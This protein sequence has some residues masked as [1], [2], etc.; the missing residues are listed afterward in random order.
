MEA[1]SRQL[2]WRFWRLWTLTAGGAGAAGGLIAYLFWAL[3]PTPF[4]FLLM[5]PPLPGDFGFPGCFYFECMLLLALETFAVTGAILTLAFTVAG[6]LVIQRA[7]RRPLSWRLLL[8]LASGAFFGGLV[9]QAWLIVAAGIRELSGP[10]LSVPFLSP[11][12]ILGGGMGMGQWL[13]LRRSS[14]RSA[15]WPLA[16]SL[17][18]VVFMPIG[19][20]LAVNGLAPARHTFGT[21][22]WDVS[23]LALWSALS[24]LVY[25]SFTGVALLW[26]LRDPRRS[27]TTIAA[28]TRHE[29]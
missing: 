22:F 20:V 17:G 1:T 19:Y 28:T 16:C 3:N 15:Y 21:F 8:A 26:I 23:R 4:L 18:L 11:W 10:W 25:G 14:P 7:V 27:P 9:A 12:L 29:E 24:G 2:G 6:G 5:W 13:V